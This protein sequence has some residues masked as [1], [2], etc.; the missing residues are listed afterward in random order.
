MKEAAKNHGQP[1]KL[2]FDAEAVR[3]FCCDRGITRLELFGSALRDDF[4]PDSDVD[5][6]CTLRPDAHP[7]LFGWVDMEY[8]LAEIFG[9]S[10]DLVRSLFNERRR[11]AATLS[12]IF[13]AT[14]PPVTLEALT[15]EPSRRE[16]VVRGLAASTQTVLEY[17]QVLGQLEGIEGVE[18]KYSTS[19]VT[20]AGERT[21]FEL[22][23]RMRS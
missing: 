20:P 14:P 11:F 15:V 1:M 7:T 8:K 13:Q 17:I 22:M 18:L 4:R 23:L 5:L 10:V 21:N 19:R 16:I 12:G 6:L 3:Q 2:Q 9:R